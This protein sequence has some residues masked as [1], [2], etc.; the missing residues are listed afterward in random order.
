MIV[1]AG[2]VLAEL[3]KAATGSLAAAIWQGVLLAGA[4]ALGL[5]LL[6]K[7]PATVR[8]AIWFGVFLL[9]TALPIVAI[10]PNHSPAGAV[11]NSGHGPWLVLDEHWC[12]AIA[13]VWVIASLTRAV[14]LVVAA[15]RVRALWTR[16]TPVAGLNSAEATLRGETAKDGAPDLSAAS[17]RQAQV[18]VS[19]EVDR[20]TVIGFFAPKILIPAWL[21]EKLTSA[22]LEQ[23]VLHEAGHLGRADD[24]MNLIQKIALV[25]FPL[26]PVLAWVERRL[27]FERE[28]AVDEHVLHA[29][30]GKPGAAKAYAEC[31]AT[32]AEYRLERRGFALGLVLG[33]FGRES[34]LGKRV[35]R[36][37][38]QRDAMKP[39]H[40]RLLMGG[41]ML[42][43]LTAATGFEHCP[44]L[45]GFSQPAVTGS[46]EQGTAV[47]T[48]THLV[49]PDRGFRAMSVR[50][51]MASGQEWQTSGDV[52]P[53]LV[54]KSHLSN[55]IQSKHHL[56]TEHSAVPVS[57]PTFRPET[58]QPYRVV[59]TVS[60]S[61][62]VLA[63]GEVVITRWVAVSSVGTQKTRAVQGIANPRRDFGDSQDL[64]GSQ[65]EQLTAPVHSYAAVPVQ[66]G[67]LVFQL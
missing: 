7:T 64:Q 3:S 12:L 9:A 55:E 15:F 65:K 67:W 13:G 19:D 11:G 14:T 52:A 47:A 34:E 48:A 5:K 1:L 45:I 39:I 4:A 16:A 50:A 59:E 61:Q 53:Q 18:C 43:L 41:A 42:I 51:N 54:T 37:L 25:L 31:L 38:E 26:N 66:G 63:G 35:I 33:L 36:I 6:P 32:L 28:L 21:L 44:Q 10:W 58:T 56:K 46:R 20:P 40:A 17:G 27:C 22:E 2:S 30:A 62:E 60:S 57:I 8:F 24:W 23:V 49:T 29:F